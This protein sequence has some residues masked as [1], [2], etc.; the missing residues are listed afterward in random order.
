MGY[1]P[2]DFYDLGDIDQ[3]G[4]LK[5]WFGSKDELSSLIKTAHD[6][7]L[8]IYADLVL[9]H[10]NGADEEEINPVD[11]I[12][13]WTKY[14]PGSGKFARNWEHYHPSVYEAW[15]QMVFEGM[16]DLCHRNPFVYTEL[17]EYARWL[18]EDL[19][20]DGFRY[21]CVRGYGAWMVHAIQELRGIKNGKIFKPFGV[22]EC[23]AANRSI[24]DWLDGANASAENPAA[25]FDFEL[26]YKLKDMCHDDHFSLR[27]LV[28][29]TT[30]LNDEPSLA[31]TFVENHDVVRNDPVIKDKMLAYA[32]ILTH[33]GYPCV[34]WQDYYNWDLAQENNKS[35]IAA[36]IHVHE[37]Y[38][39]GNTDILYCDDNLYIMQRSGRGDQ[40]GLI[41][42]LNTQPVWNGNVV[43][44]KWKNTKFIPLAWRGNNNTDI[45]AEKQS[46]ENG[47]A[48]FWAPP[49][50]YVV[51]VPE[52]T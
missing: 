7:D 38:A 19:E 20:V 51:Y 44:A 26:R 46:D 32:F 30:L 14:N 33:E 40:Q 43:Q 23:W 9:N 22:G 31:V 4:S 11:G 12:K 45:P 41:F 52:H 21:D 5:T 25:A 49:R 39:G 13:R 6:N 17:L 29:E 34:F 42:V 8:D 27:R 50:G 48:D 28:D 36:L 24:E 47:V 15:D 1:D 16:P 3:K 18:M 35:G 10:T 2:Y 37:S